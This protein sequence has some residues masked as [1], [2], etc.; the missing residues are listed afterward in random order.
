M[1]GQ[2]FNRCSRQNMNWVGGLFR[3]HAHYASTVGMKRTKMNQ[4]TPYMQ[5]TDQLLTIEY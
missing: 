1:R 5:Y 2:T 3:Q 4:N